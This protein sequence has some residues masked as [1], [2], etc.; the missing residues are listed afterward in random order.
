M[1][2]AKCPYGVRLLAGYL[3]TPYF[4]DKSDNIFYEIQHLI[5]SHSNF[6]YTASAWAVQN[7]R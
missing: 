1:A 2:G 3:E 7:T 4:F 6:Q 5:I